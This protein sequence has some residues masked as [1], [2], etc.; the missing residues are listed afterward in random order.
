MRADGSGLPS[1]A[2]AF[3]DYQARARRLAEASDAEIAGA[4][5]RACGQ[6]TA[7]LRRHG[8]PAG[9]AADEAL[10][11]AAGDLAAGDISGVLMTLAGQRLVC[12]DD[13]CMPD[14]DALEDI[15]RQAAA[16][17]GGEWTALDIEATL[18]PARPAPGWGASGLIEARLAF[19]TAGERHVWEFDQSG[20]G[21]SAEYYELRDEFAARHL[22]GRFLTVDTGDQCHCSVYL[23]AEAAAQ[24]SQVL[25]GLPGGHPG[26]PAWPGYGDFYDRFS[27]IPRP[28]RA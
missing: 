1:E 23:P 28:D 8:L 12:Y 5:Q 21:V 20:S 22:P 4:G 3:W 27:A 17:T 26:S 15:V 24:I 25:L 13:R 10:A 16:A 6:I 7:I 11:A 2:A 19:T 9:A 18:T 14:E